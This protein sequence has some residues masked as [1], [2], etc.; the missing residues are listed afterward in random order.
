ML[1]DLNHFEKLDS[2]LPVSLLDPVNLLIAFAVILFF[3]VF[4]Y[5]LMVLPFHFLFYVWQPPWTRAKQIYP[6]LPKKKEQLFELKW[7]LWTSLIFAGMGVV[8]GVMWQL[9]WTRIYLR[10]DEYGWFYFF[11][12]WIPFL[13]LHD[14]YFYWTHIWLHRPEVYARYH[15]I[16]HKSLRPSPWASFSFHPVESLVNALA[17]P[18]IVIILPLHPLVIIFHLTFMTI[19]AITNHLGFEI[20]PTWALKR[21]WDK[22]L[23]SGTHHANHHRYF[24]ANYGLFFTFWDRLKKTERTEGTSAGGAP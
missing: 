9:G 17:I 21:N 23:I 18:L 4:R 3:V 16:H 10:F 22:I 15:M 24:K 7:S 20:L 8:L 5:F 11:F 6:Q 2:Y 14:T 1:T 19:S 12:S 13:L